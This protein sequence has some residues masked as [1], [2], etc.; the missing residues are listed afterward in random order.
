MNAN[1][2]L[3][4]KKAARVAPDGLISFPLLSAI[5]GGLSGLI[6]IL[7]ADHFE[8]RASVRTDLLQRMTRAAEVEC[9]SRQTI[10]GDFKSG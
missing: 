5:L 8:G 1:K 4:I 10:V 3:E 2:I 9:G 6:G 7:P